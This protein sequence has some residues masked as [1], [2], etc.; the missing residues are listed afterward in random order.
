[1]NKD[2]KERMNVQNDKEFMDFLHFFSLHGISYRLTM[3]QLLREKSDE[4][5]RAKIHGVYKSRTI[6]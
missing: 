3:I 1:M 5:L 6:R 4:L 2:L